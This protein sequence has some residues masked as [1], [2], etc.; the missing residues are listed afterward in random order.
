[1]PTIP[2]PIPT[3]FNKHKKVEIEPDARY[4]LTFGIS[5]VISVISLFMSIYVIIYK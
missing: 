4:L 5:L 1:M 2:P 3:K